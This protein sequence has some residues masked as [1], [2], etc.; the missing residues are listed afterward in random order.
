MWT[1]VRDE[2]ELPKMMMRKCS[3]VAE[4]ES[5]LLL[6]LKLFRVKKGWSQVRST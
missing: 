5:F 1:A 6:Y 3:T 4:T 2:I